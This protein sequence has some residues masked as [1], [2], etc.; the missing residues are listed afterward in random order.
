MKLKKKLLAT[1]ACLATV[2]SVTTICN[3]VSSANWEITYYPHST[4]P[5]N[6]PSDTVVLGYCSD[7]YIAHCENITGG[8][9]RQVTITSPSCGGIKGGS[10]SITTTGNTSTFKLW[11][12]TTGNVTF[13]FTA[14]EDIWCCADGS[15]YFSS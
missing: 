9:G 6:I 2:F 14:T 1:V 3:A 4:Y 10:K 7:G 5:Y 15:I 11:N 8:Q 13:V 12:S